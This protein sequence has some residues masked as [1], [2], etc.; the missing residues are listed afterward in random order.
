MAK[1]AH[2]LGRGLDSLFEETED[3]NSAGLQEIPIGELDINPDQPRKSFD[4]ESIALE[5]GTLIEGTY[6]FND[7]SPFELDSKRIDDRKRIKAAQTV[8]ERTIKKLIQARRSYN[9]E[10]L[11]EQIPSDIWVGDKVRVLYDNSIWEQTECSSYWK[12]ILAMDDWYY[13]TR[14][15]YEFDENGVETNR[16]TLTKW[17]RI[18]RETNNYD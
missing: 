7:M 1:K 11:T 16:L 6:A 3:W 13:I 8:Y 10:V 4:E 12:K 9:I 18:E 14:I 5:S 2:G 15:E 17:I